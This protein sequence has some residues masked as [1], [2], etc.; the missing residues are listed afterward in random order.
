MWFHSL[1]IPRLV[2]SLM[3]INSG[4]IQERAKRSRGFWSLKNNN[5]FERRVKNNNEGLLF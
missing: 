4:R 3:D 5:E 1:K 2:F